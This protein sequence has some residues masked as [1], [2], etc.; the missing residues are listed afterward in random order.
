MDVRCHQTHRHATTHNHKCVSNVVH[1]STTRKRK[2]NSHLHPETRG[3]C[4]HHTVITCVSVCSHPRWG[5][6]HTHCVNLYRCFCDPLSPRPSCT[7]NPHQVLPLDVIVNLHSHSLSDSCL[8]PL[9]TLSRPD[10]PAQT[11]P[12]RAALS[13][14]HVSC[15]RVRLPDA[16][17]SQT[18]L[19]R[20]VHI[21][22]LH[23]PLQQSI[24]LQSCS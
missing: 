1:N 7:E 14:L 2:D 11:L 19:Q 8:S 3:V 12:L 21:A 23:L 17:G 22:V 20:P 24:A 15:M 6:P 10:L 18:R 5:N 16:L 4:R 13:S 9:E